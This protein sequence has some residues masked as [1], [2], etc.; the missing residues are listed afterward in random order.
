[1]RLH[2]GKE[3]NGEE[4]LRYLYLA[5]EA[6]EATLSVRNRDTDT[7]SWARA[8]LNLA[9]VFR[10]LGEREAETA[11]DHLHESVHRSE[12]ALAVT[13]PEVSPALWAYIQLDL[14]EVVTTLGDHLDGQQRLD[15]YLRAESIL[16]D[17]EARAPEVGIE[18]LHIEALRRSV[19]F[20]LRMNHWDRVIEAGEALMD[21]RSFALF[22]AGTSYELG[23]IYKSLTGITEAVAFAFAKQGLVERALV[24][25]ETGR[26]RGLRDHIQ[27]KLAGLSEAQSNRLKDLRKELERK[28]QAFD[29]GSSTSANIRNSVLSDLRQSQTALEDMIRSAGLL[30][31]PPPS[32]LWHRAVAK[33]TLAVQISV[34]EVGT[35]AIVIPGDAEKLDERNVLFV[36]D[37]DGA[38]LAELLSGEN[39]WLGGYQAFRDDLLQTSGRGSAAGLAEWSWRIEQTLDQLWAL[40][41]PI[42]AKLRELGAQPDAPIAMI[43]PGHLAGLPLHAAGRRQGREWRCFLDAWTPS[44]VPSIA[45]LGYVS[46]LIPIGNYLLAITDPEKDFV[47]ARNPAIAHFDAGSQTELIGT[48][49]TRAAT[50]AALAQADYACFLCHGVWQHDEAEQSGLRLADGR[51]TVADLRATSLTRAP[52]IALGACETA[53]GSL[54]AMANEM[55]GLPLALIQA[56]ARGVAATFWPVFGHTADI[57]LD[58]FFRGHRQENLAPAAAMRRAVL[59]MR[60]GASFASVPIAKAAFRTSFRV[61]SSISDQEE[62][63][64]SRAALLRDPANP[65]HWAVYGYY[66]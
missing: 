33:G 7:M 28:R 55:N 49:A 21:R 65:L 60:D 27:Q 8:Q 54:G 1:L 11:L 50:L 9:K 40:M 46:S 18:I 47:G 52:I 44:Y 58:M 57:I 23:Q 37:F 5:I 45:A 35:L 59:A 19:A 10:V 31:E 39:S 29:T 61:F 17:I 12:A 63:Q 13:S 2:L 15:Q 36:A 30:P 51:L 64:A 24:A 66:G 34:T 42:D 14:S 20:A 56:G 26:A 22:G 43:V 48:K 25:A 4:G 53:L 38:R 62:G 32:D 16:R 6:Y 41:A 3:L